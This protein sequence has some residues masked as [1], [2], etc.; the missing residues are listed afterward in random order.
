MAWVRFSIKACVLR[1]TWLLHTPY[2]AGTARC[3]LEPALLIG[4]GLERI[5]IIADQDPGVH[6]LGNRGDPFLQAVGVF[7]RQLIDGQHQTGEGIHRDPE[8]Q[9]SAL[10]LHAGH[11]GSQGLRAIALQKPTVPFHPGN[12]LRNGLDRPIY[13]RLAH[14]HP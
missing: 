2:L 4:D 1:T 10:A 5:R 7:A 11:I 3:L 8:G 12:L 14:P 13:R 9:P 6:A